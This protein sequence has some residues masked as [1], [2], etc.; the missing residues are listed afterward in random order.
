M[1]AG[2]DRLVD[3]GRQ[4]FGQLGGQDLEDAVLFRHRS[5]GQLQTLLRLLQLALRLLLLGDVGHH[6]HGAAGSRAAAA[7][8]VVAAVRR[9]ILETRSGRMLDAFDA[10]GDERLDLSFAV[11]TAFGEVAQEVGIR[12]AGLQQLRRNA[13]HFL[14]ALIAEDD[15]DVLVGVDERARH[16]IERDVELRL[17]LP[18]RLLG[19]LLFGDV[20]HHG[21]G[22]ARSRAAA[23]DA[24][25]PS[26]G[27]AVL[28]T[29]ARGVAQAFN[30]AGDVRLDVAFAV[31]AVLGEIAKEGRIW[32]SRSQQV[33]RGAIHLLEAIVAE[34]DSQILVSVNERA[35]HVVEGNE[36]VAVPF[37]R[38][39][40]AT[41]GNGFGLSCHVCPHRHKE[42]G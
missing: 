13:V 32:L 36:K 23:Q 40:A 3:L 7:D 19:E 20:R 11:V 21:D 35:W 34:N 10:P 18:E 17:L 27:S 42:Q 2:E 8:A 5:V 22:A 4:V 25:D 33:G 30:P 14:E 6:R 9:A 12:P 37:F 31:V 28:E 1:F 15:V 16:V 39:K 38:R 41:T 29:L 26:V 24:V